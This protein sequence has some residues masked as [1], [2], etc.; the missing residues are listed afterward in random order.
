[1]SYRCRRLQTCIKQEFTRNFDPQRCAGRFY[2][3]TTG[4]R[5][6]AA[7]IEIAQVQ[8]ES[9]LRD[10]AMRPAQQS[11]EAAADTP[12]NIHAA[13]RRLEKL[14]GK[15]CKSRGWTATITWVDA[16]QSN[17]SAA[18]VGPAAAQ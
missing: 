12:D 2:S 11:V 18:V 13:R 10:A 6:Q 16:C 14:L 15:A 9:N 8:R 7:G 3:G 4:T 1:M 5:T 17:S